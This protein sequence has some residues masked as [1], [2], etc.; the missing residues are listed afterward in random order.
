[1]SS[2]IFYDAVAYLQL[3]YL[4]KACVH[5]F[6]VR[7]GMSGRAVSLTI[8]GLAAVLLC[9][10]AWAGGMTV[11]LTFDSSFTSSFAN[12]PNNPNE[13]SQAEAAANYAASQIGA[14]FNNTIA[15]R[16]GNIIPFPLNI[17]VSGVSDTSIFGQSV[18]NGSGPYSYSEIRS[19]LVA[20][21]IGQ[22]SAAAVAALPTS[23]PAGSN[24][25]YL[26]SAEATALGFQDRANQVYGTISFGAGYHWAF[27]PS[28]RAVAGEYDFIG[29]VEHE[30][31]EVMGRIGLTGEVGPNLLPAY[32]PLDLF[33]Y[34]AAG[35]HAPSGTGA[36]IYFSTDNGVTNLHTYNDVDVATRT[37]AGDWAGG[38][39]ND[40]FNQ[41]FTTG[42]VEGI[43]PVDIQE[44]NVIGWTVAVPE[45]S[46][47]SLFA[48][49]AVVC[50]TYSRRRSRAI[51]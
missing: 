34:S 7:A 5:M 48:L 44:L 50:G 9:S 17:N 21:S 42:V 6:F 8:I 38:Q 26:T 51:A 39:G 16:N 31:T 13:L 4:M 47:L 1:V 2:V 14:L 45:P 18:T 15:D 12:N 37:D 32:S 27:D 46:S 49:G 36:G 11:N 43:T 10:N 28:N 33:R 25:Y 24:N 23:D 41:F 40:S 30:I 19:A 22:P 20:N 29:A 3:P 35:V